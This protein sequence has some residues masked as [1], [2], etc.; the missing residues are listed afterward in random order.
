MG[1]DVM[2][3]RRWFFTLLFLCGGVLTGRDSRADGLIR[4]GLGAISTGRGGT[5]IGFADNGAVIN[6]NPGA[7]VN[8]AGN[9][10][11]DLNVDTVIPEIS[12]TDPKPNDVQS[13]TRPLPTPQL[14]YIQRSKDRRWAWGLGVFAPAGFGAAYDFQNSFAGPQLYKSTAAVGK[15]LPSLSY[16]LTD[17]LSIGGT[18]GLAL[19]YLDIQGPVYLQTGVLRGAPLVLDLQNFGVAP[20]GSFGMQYLLSEKTTLGLTYITETQFKMAGSMDA[21]AYG[22]GPAPLYSK[23]S[24]QTNIIWP[25]SLGAGLS[26]KLN[27]RNI[28]AADVIWYDWHNAFNQ[29]N[30][31]LTNP[32]NPLVPLLA[33]TAIPQHVAENWRD[34][35]SLRLGYQWLP[36]TVNIFRA[37]Y[38][39]HASP[40]PNNTLTPYTDGILE[41]AFSLGYSRKIGRA[42]LNAAYQYS[43]GPTRYVGT[44]IL[45]GGDFNNSTLR[46]QLHIASLGVLVPF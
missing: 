31:N 24:A 7:L 32:S 23:F 18:M 39:Y 12:Y 26:H 17:R 45:A 9:G 13:H 27:K 14:A 41:H 16:R 1:S 40:A 44:S 29:L 4:D 3:A 2:L 36:D 43:F 8:V 42:Y 38:V 21:L 46:T 30:V 33:G 15:L 11:L 25:R 22:L 37:G 20:T 6:D 19:S 35:V 34:T 28:V 5:N 10:L